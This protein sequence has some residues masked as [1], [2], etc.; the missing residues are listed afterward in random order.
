MASTQPHGERNANT[1][2]LA[3][4][5]PALER[6]SWRSRRKR[7]PFV[8]QLERA[9]CG[10]ACLAMVL[11]FHGK[12]VR[13]EDA[14][15]AVGV[16]LDGASALSILTAAQDY[17]MRGRGISLEIED[18]R[19]LPRASIL[20][21]DF[22]HFV[23]FD[24]VV[25]G[26]VEIVDP[27]HGRRRVPM[28]QFH[29]A[30]TG[31]AL[32]IEPTAQF[33]P[34]KAGRSRTWNYLRQLLAQRHLLSRV[35]M[36]S[37]ILRMLALSLPILTA[38]IV[39]RVVPR[40]DTALLG[41]VGF[42]LA[43]AMGFRLL[44]TL[45]RAHMLLQ[46]RTNLDTRLTLGFL[47]HLA[48]LP[49]AFFQ[50]RSAGDLMMR[51]SSN[52][53]IREMLTS[54]TLSGLL[55]GTLVFVYLVLIFAIHPGLALLT[56]ALGALQVLVFLFSRTRVADLMSENL[57]AQARAQS[58]LVQMLAGIETL[59]VAGAESRAVEHWS[60]LFVDELNVSLKQ[61]RLRA[62]LDTAMSGLQSSAPLLVLSYG[63]VEVMAGNL[64]LGNMLALNALAAGFLTPLASLVTSALRLQLLGS[65]VERIDDVLLADREQDRDRVQRPGK[66][67]GLITVRGV[68]FRYGPQSPLVVRDV[69]VEILP[70]Q[71]VAIVG[72][73]GSGKSTLAKLLLGLYQPTEGGIYYDDQNL[74]DLDFREMRRQLGIVPQH[75]FIFGR[76]VRENIAISDP[77][78]GIDRVMEA[79]QL[80]SIHEEVAAM[81]MGYES[82]LADGGASLSGGQRQRIAMARALVNQP[83][84]L[85]LDEATSSLD[86]ASERTVMD[87]LAAHNCTRIMIAHRLST[88]AFAD[89]IIVMDQGQIV[90][91]GSHQALMQKK[92]AYHALVSV[93]SDRGQDPAEKERLHG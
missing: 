83:A 81:P 37:V 39:D 11:R 41:I 14:R 53:T 82:I 24:R 67:T 1:P 6:L 3:K 50:R 18:L 72:R 68:S 31:V 64:S 71:C 28:D 40:G 12:E 60:N 15:Q 77:A 44:S 73:S 88:I 9:D 10:A 46:L 2:D 33:E 87:N 80:A 52:S 16:G 91:K 42:G 43:A 45:I 54:N 90:E 32:V 92:G 23:V 74:A 5:F 21:W 89:E 36:T 61:G 65:Y 56:V 29:R 85:L 70:G 69:S 84:I 51:V 49:Y 8:Q 35:V 57:E 58:Y 47:D 17:G 75:P 86:N 79:A 93:Q 20:H 78:T 22:S 62:V 59:K 26:A 34:S 19:H 7:V 76:S 38:L 30:F 63:A 55:D 27:G 13:L 25:D 66:L 48:N 4:D